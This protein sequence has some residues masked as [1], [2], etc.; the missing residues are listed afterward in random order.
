MRNIEAADIPCEK[1]AGAPD[2]EIEV[3]PAMIEA[4]L[5]VLWN[6]GALETPM[7][8]ADRILVEEMFRAM[9]RVVIRPASPRSIR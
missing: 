3:T 2:A 7:A 1:S 4:G 5:D 8:G 6:S 9:Y